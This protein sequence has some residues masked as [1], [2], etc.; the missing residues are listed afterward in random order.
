MSKVDR[1]FRLARQMALRGD[2]LIRR[3]YR[4]G[5]LVY[6][7]MELLWFQIIFL[8]PTRPELLTQK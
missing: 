1:Y 2:K 7:V 5:M 8:A 3:Q 4:L 6:V